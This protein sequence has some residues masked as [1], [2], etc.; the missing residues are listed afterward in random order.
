METEDC[1]NEPLQST[2]PT[3]P[4]LDATTNRNI[5]HIC[6]RT[7]TRD[8]NEQ[9]VSQQ[10]AGCIALARTLFNNSP[11]I[12][13]KSPDNAANMHDL[14]ASPNKTQSVFRTCFTKLHSGSHLNIN[15]TIE[16]PEN[17][18]DLIKLDNVQQVFQQHA[19]SV[20]HTNFMSP[21][22]TTIGFIFGRTSDGLQYGR[23]Y[24]VQQLQ[25]R[26]KEMAELDIPIDITHTKSYVH[27][28]P[29]PTTQGDK[30]RTHLNDIW[31]VHVKRKHRLLIE[32]KFDTGQLFTIHKHG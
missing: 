9:G 30:K 24:H 27:T 15:V 18:F 21:D 17:W 7:P 4:T 22:I 5:F 14:H 19:F 2:N 31:D 16:M 25:D 13:F 28:L 26:I 32:T 3:D 20:Q 12:I 23:N 29:A 1:L 10:I 11:N 8:Y 6:T